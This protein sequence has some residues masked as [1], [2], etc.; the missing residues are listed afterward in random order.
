[1]NSESKENILLVIER[2]KRGRPKKVVI[3]LDE[4]VEINK[5]GRGRPKKEILIKERVPVGRPKKLDIIDKVEYN[6]N[7]Y[8]QNKD[9]VKIVGDFVC[10]HC[11]KISSLANKLRHLKSHHPEII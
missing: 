4:N 10:P 2:V 6:K 3:N 11:N 9:R 1:M 5:R 8:Q 7:Y